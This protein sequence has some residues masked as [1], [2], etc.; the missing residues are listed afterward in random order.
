M[1][2]LPGAQRGNG[3]ECKIGVSQK[4]KTYAYVASILLCLGV[5]LFISNL[6]SPVWTHNDI[7]ITPQGAVIKPEMW[8][9]SVERGKDQYITVFVILTNLT[10]RALSVKIIAKGELR[11]LVNFYSNA[12]DAEAKGNQLSFE[13]INSFRSRYIF[14]SIKV[15]DQITRIQG[16]IILVNV[17]DGRTLASI[18]VFLVVG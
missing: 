16:H 17:A 5:A 12:I 2:W 3:G 9:F 10:G 4:Q 6:R 1:V 14:L 18:P 13:K 8:A 11:D 7:K 15:P